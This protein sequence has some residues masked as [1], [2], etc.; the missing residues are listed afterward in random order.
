MINKY[1]H[2]SLITLVVCTFL[3]G[4]ITTGTNGVVKIGPDLYMIGGLGRFTDFSSSGIKAR[5][6]KQ[7]SDF[8]EKQGRVM[9]PVTSTGKDSEYGQY[10][11]AEIQFL[12]LLPSDPRINR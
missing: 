4:C 2:I 7:A 6:Y 5:L 11:S 9:V 8:C 3:S 12:C 1:K 10:A